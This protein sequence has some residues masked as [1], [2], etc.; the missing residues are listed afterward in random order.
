[1]EVLMHSPDRTL[2]PVALLDEREAADY[3]RASPHTLRGWRCKGGGPRFVK[4]G[5]KVVYR[6]ADLDAW[7]TERTRAHTSQGRAA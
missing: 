6:V 1:M 3:L 4:V 5:R 2:S 7:M